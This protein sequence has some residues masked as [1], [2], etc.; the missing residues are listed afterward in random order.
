MQ[1]TMPARDVLELN[2]ARW[3]DGSG[4]TFAICAA[5]DGCVGHVWVNFSDD[6]LGAVGYWLLPE[7]RG[8]GFAGLL[9]N[10]RGD[11]LD[12]VREQGASPASA[13]RRSP[14]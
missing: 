7:A 13:M 12:Q 14:R 5:D 10:R 9:V 4:P 1:P 8:Q 11:L 3:L 6:G 2:R